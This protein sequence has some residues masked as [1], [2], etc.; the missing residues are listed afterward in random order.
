VSDA[1]ATTVGGTSM[2]RYW[3]HPTQ[4]P[5]V[6]MSIILEWRTQPDPTPGVVAQELVCFIC[7][8][9]DNLVRSWPT[10]TPMSE[11]INAAV[12]HDKLHARYGISIPARDRRALR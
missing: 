7:P 11:V 5:V 4:K 9:D 2:D 10:T 3:L 12:A 1:T 8:M 6:L